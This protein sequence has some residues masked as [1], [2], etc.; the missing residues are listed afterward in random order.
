MI[1]ALQSLTTQDRMISIISQQKQ[2]FQ[3]MTIVTIIDIT[4]QD[5]KITMLIVP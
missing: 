1:H 2:S 4:K 5:K 3:T